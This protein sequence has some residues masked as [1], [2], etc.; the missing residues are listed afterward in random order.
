MD[1]QKNGPTVSC[2]VVAVP[3]PGPGHINP[4]MCLCELLV[5]RR[6]HDL[7][8]TFVV[9]EE[10]FSF[11]GSD[12]KSENVRFAKIPNV[13]PSEIGRGVD[14]PAFYEAVLR[15]MRAPLEDLLDRLDTPA[16]DIVADTYLLLSADVGIRR[17]VPV[18]SLW[19]S[20]A[21]VYSVFHHFDLLIQ[22]Q[23]FPINLKDSPHPPPLSLSPLPLPVSL[24][25]PFN[26]CRRRPQ[27]Q[28][29][30]GDAGIATPGRN[31]HAACDGERETRSRRE[32]RSCR[33]R[34][35][36]RSLRPSIAG[37]ARNRDGLG[38]LRSNCNKPPPSPPLS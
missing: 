23:H 32:S 18:A 27:P 15:N 4:M 14:Q 37:S 36:S 20:S 28:T 5:L 8:V 10:W 11:I 17:N 38:I 35:S 16:N 25:S 31:R 30:T 22:N 1:P 2:H 3:F 26:H 29:E 24:F 21:M 19:T 13:I 34:K 9:T 6:K 33:R 12:P 7:L